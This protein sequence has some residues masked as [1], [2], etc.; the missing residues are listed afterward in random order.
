MTREQFVS[1]IEGVYQQGIE[2]IKRKN[3]A[4]GG[5]V[6]PFKNFFVVESLEI[7]TAEEAILVRL[8]DK[9][10]RLATL[11]ARKEKNQVADETVFDTLI[12][13]INYLGILYAL[14]KKRE[15]ELELQD[16]RKIAPPPDPNFPDTTGIIEGGVES[17][18]YRL[19]PITRI[20]DN[21]AED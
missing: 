12:D 17:G 18:N 11:I 19:P 21:P 4:Y 8:S 3:A 9:F 20:T 14:L 10:S 5:A 16:A 6:D 13:A 1:I 2:I 7:A 15:E